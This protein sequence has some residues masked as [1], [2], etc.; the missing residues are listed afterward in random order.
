MLYLAC[1]LID[2]LQKYF[3]KPHFLF[4]PPN[5]RR[6]NNRRRGKRIFRKKSNLSFAICTSYNNFI[7][8]AG[9]MHITYISLGSNVGDR[10]HYL[11]EAK[12]LLQERVGKVIKESAILETTPWGV[13]DLQGDYLNQI[14]VLETRLQPLALLILTQNIE[15]ELGR[16]LKGK[17]QPRTIDLDIL[18]Y[19]DCIITL[20]DLIIPHPL[21]HLRTFI[22]ENMLQIAPDLWHPKEKKMQKEFVIL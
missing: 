13:K 11:T 2:F 15:K 12:R 17:N 21:A 9:N 4:K 19:D 18:Y 5:P 6:R 20:P 1:E 22:L 3:L 16:V 10:L 8:F 7:I 14:V